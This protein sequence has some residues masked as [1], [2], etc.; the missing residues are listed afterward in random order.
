MDQLHTKLIFFAGSDDCYHKRYLKQKLISV[1]GE[2]IYFTSEERRQ[3][4]LC[5]KHSTNKILRKYEKEK[6]QN[7]DDKKKN[8]ILTCAKLLVDDIKASD[9]NNETYPTLS[10]PTKPCTSVPESMLFFLR[11]FTKSD[12]KAEVWGQ[13]FVKSLRPR[14]G[15]MPYHMGLAI[16]LDHRFGS[17]WL[18]ERFHEL[19]YCESYKELNQYKWS[20]LCTKSKT[21]LPEVCVNDS[22]GICNIDE[23]EEESD[24]DD[25]I[26]YES[27]ASDDLSECDEEGDE[28]IRNFQRSDRETMDVIEQYVG[29][30]IDLNIGSLYGNTAFHAMGIIRITTP[31]PENVDE[32]QLRRG[33][34]ISG[35]NK[36]QVLNNI[37]VKLI[38]YCKNV[39]SLH[40]IVFRPIDE[41]IK[42]FT[43]V[44]PVLSPADFGW[45]VGL[46]NNRILLLL[47]QIGKDL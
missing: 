43:T 7:D 22:N 27:F 35:D 2:T 1:Y 26:V 34:K 12:E 14:S 18:I 4:I 20:F 16:Q 39:S 25:D 45:L 13:N 33:L 44:K 31:K 17:K 36:V 40:S 42:A 15:V 47:T 38:P 28:S 9:I 30:N 19:G 37:E 24:S 29:D 5:F 46:S 3:D 23:Q 6:P 10:E 21:V 32:L 41:L 8:I 11:H